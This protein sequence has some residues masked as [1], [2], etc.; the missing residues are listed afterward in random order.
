MGALMGGAVGGIAGDLAGKI[1]G[2]IAADYMADH[3][4][5]EII[6][7]IDRQAAQPVI[8]AI[9]KVTQ[10]DFLNLID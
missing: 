2:D 10:K 3:W 6:D 1:T 5:E 7:F 9:N 8:E 4:R